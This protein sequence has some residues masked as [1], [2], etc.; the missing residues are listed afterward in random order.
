[1]GRCLRVSLTDLSL[2]LGTLQLVQP[3]ASP[4]ASQDSPPS[5]LR[6]RCQGPPG[7]LQEKLL[8]AAAYVRRWSSRDSRCQVLRPRR[9]GTLFHIPCLE[10]PALCKLVCA[11]NTKS[12]ALPALAPAPVGRHPNPPPGRRVRGEKRARRLLTMHGCKRVVLTVYFHRGAPDCRP[13][14]AAASPAPRGCPKRLTSRAAAAAGPGTVELELRK[15]CCGPPGRPEIGDGR[16]LLLEAG[17]RARALRL[18]VGRPT[19]GG[20]LPRAGSGGGSGPESG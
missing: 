17:K 20:F 5:T 3:E 13:A 11:A 16:E 12:W 8:L 14:H 7:R 1:M 19:P 6:I 18:E 4:V 9:P 15:H 10:S 2:Q